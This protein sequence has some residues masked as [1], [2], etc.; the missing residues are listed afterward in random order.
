M[1][2]CKEHRVVFVAIPKTGTRS[3]YGI[4]KKYFKGK[5]Y[6]E[7]YDVVPAKYKNYFKFT[8]I[9]NPYARAVSLWW[10][11]CKRGNDK[12]GFIKESGGDSLELFLKFLIS[13]K[14]SEKNAT[15]HLLRTQS[16]YLKANKYDAILKME[17]LEE[18]FWNL[19]FINPV[20]KLRIIKERKAENKDVFPRANATF[21]STE[22]IA[23]TQAY[24]KKINKPKILYRS[25]KWEHYMTPE[26]IKMINIIYADDF[27][28]LKDY[29]KKIEPETWQTMN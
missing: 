22:K 19:K 21:A 25:N 28:M 8:T 27:K 20:E 24:R 10:S 17:S 11:T 14:N 15:F 6:K 1:I 18:D 7:H 5:L 9:R 3:T 29:Y 12:R 26:I 23:N 2:I 4:L 13:N 16:R